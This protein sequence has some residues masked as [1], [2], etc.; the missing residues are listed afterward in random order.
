VIHTQM[1]NT[2]PIC[3]NSVS[4]PGHLGIRQENTIPSG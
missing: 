3:G 1:H 4:V 2:K